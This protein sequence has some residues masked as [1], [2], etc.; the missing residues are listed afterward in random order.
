MSIELRDVH[1]TYKLGKVDVHAIRGISLKIKDGE[2]ASIQGQSGSGKSTLLHLIGCLDTP[3]K[4]KVI[5]NGKDTSKMPEDE[6]ARLRRDTIGFVFQQYNLIS[7]LTAMENISFPLWIKGIPLE[8]RLKRARE[9][10]ETVGLGARAHHRP[11]ELSGGE[12]Q[13]VAIARALANQPP[14]LLADEPTGNLDSKTGAEIT[15][16]LKKIHRERKMALI[17]VTHDTGLAKQAKHQINIKDG[18]ILKG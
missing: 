17:M 2:F 4:G 5:V 18:R 13:R 1:K 15:A 12:M 6:L 9:L 8:S 16:L 3:T 11:T 10:L 7:K 14:I